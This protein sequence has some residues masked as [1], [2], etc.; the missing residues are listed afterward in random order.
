MSRT[1]DVDRLLGEARKAGLHVEAHGS[2][3]RVTNAETGGQAFVPTKGAGRSLANIRSD[4]RRLAAPS[5]MVAATTTNPQE[6]PVAWPIEELIHQAGQEGVHLAVKGGLLH[7]SGPVDAE[8]LARLL[9]DRAPEVLAH[10]NPP[11][12]KDETPVPQIRDIAHIAVPVDDLAS[13]AQA[14]W[15]IL[16][17]KAKADGDEPGTNAGAAGVLW[18]GARDRVLR[19]LAPEWD[20]DYRQ[21]IGQYLEQTGHAKCQSRHATPPIWWIAEAWSDGGLAVAKRPVPKPGPPKVLS[22]ALTDE[23]L[24]AAITA[25]LAR[26]PQVAARVEEL[27]TANQA[28][29]SRVEDL[30]GELAERDARLAKFEA[31]AAIFRGGAL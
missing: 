13:D 12:E 26:D 6:T 10:L 21:K 4:L 17:E 22:A 11:N 16:R 25:R 18:R 1:G 23:Q 9:R 29:R 7:V 24:L 28:L 14:V 30:S 5:P 3:W 20:A 19:E 2:K 8:P 15:S 31:A 27:E